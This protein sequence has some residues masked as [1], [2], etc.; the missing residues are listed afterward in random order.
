MWLKRVR[1]HGHKNTVQ[2]CAWSPSGNLV[3]TA[4]RDQLV[5]VFD[6]RAMKELV[7][8]R[9]HKK[10]VCC[11]SP[12]HPASTTTNPH[13][14]NRLAPN[15]RRHPRFRWFRRINNPLVD[16]RRRTKRRARIRARFKRLVTR[17]SSSRSFISERFER[18]Y[19]EILESWETWSADIGG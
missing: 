11:T 3:A 7:T 5:K 18:S 4:S 9:G 6:I 10:E 19:D 15:P 1:R 13:H 2:A 14:S 16:A 17:L 8:L 12:P